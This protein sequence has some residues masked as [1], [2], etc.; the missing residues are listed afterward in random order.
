MPD[1][2]A[3]HDALVSVVMPAYNARE[4]VEEAIESALAQS[5]HPLEVIIVDDGSTDGTSD[6]IADRFGDRVRLLRMAHGGRSIARNRGIDLAR[7]AFIQFLDADDILV[8]TKVERQVGFLAENPQYAVA[9][10]S[11]ECFAAEDS[12]RRWPFKPGIHPS[13]QILP[14]MIDDGFILP[15]ATLARAEW[16]RRI[17]GFDPRLPSNEDWDFWLRMAAAGGLFAYRPIDEVV[18]FYRVSNRSPGGARG[19]PHLLGGVLALEKLGRTLSPERALH[20]ALRRAVGRWR[21][22]YGRSLLE[23]GDRW[24]G[25]REMTRALAQ[26][27]R[28][29]DYKLAW[30]VAGAL[31]GGPRAARLVDAVE[32]RIRQGPADPSAS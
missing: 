9:Y 19:D 2:S 28:S 16:C 14:H 21:F 30:I 13:G 5:H 10:G 32:R 22:G 7:G 24:G 3:G 15:V 18:G 29:W 11:V 8:R 31:L 26:D 4:T 23:A 25:L 17:G 20:P 6:L 1:A 12:D 27:P